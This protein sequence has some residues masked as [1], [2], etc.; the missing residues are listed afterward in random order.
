MRK[1]EP[2]K[3]RKSLKLLRVQ[4][5]NLSPRI[6]K[7]VHGCS[8]RL[9]VI[10]QPQLWAA[11]AH[12]LSISEPEHAFVHRVAQPNKQRARGSCRWSHIHSTQHRRTR[13]VNL[14]QTSG[15]ICNTQKANVCKFTREAQSCVCAVELYS[16]VH[17]LKISIFIDFVVG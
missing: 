11:L 6:Y 14:S 8:R 7:A 17:K 2:A 13:D 4:T 1:L 12:E 9:T 15:N 10:T 3:P 16:S 5:I